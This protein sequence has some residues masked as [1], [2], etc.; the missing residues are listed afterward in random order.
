MVP[1]RSELSS[2]CSVLP[3]AFC[4]SV[5]SAT[6]GCGVSACISVE[7]AP[8]QAADIARVL[9]QRN[10][11]A[12]ADTEEG[13]V[14]LPRVAHGLDLALDA[15]IAESHRARGSHRRHPARPVPSRSMSSAS[16]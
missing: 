3:S 7:C 4:H 13:N 12:Q 5:I 8:V 14:V 2:R 10:M 11:H 1:P 6:I 16:T 9:D 15:P